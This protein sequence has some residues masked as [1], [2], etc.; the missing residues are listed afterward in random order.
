MLIRRKTFTIVLLIISLPVLAG[1][2]SGFVSELQA[3]LESPTPLPTATALPTSTLPA[4]APTE[5][6]IPTYAT[7]PTPTPGNIAIQNLSLPKPANTQ[8]PVIL[9]LTGFSENIN[10]LT[11]LE[12]ENI[13]K[14][15]RRPVLIKVSNYP[16]YGRPHAGLSFA[17][18][19]FE[20][21]IGEE[22]NRFLALYYS[23]DCEKVGPLR[24]GRLIDAQLVNMY[25][26]V[27]AYGNADPK[28][29][30]VL[31][32]ELD[33]RAI[34]FDDAAC[35]P[36]CGAETHSVAGVFVDTAALSD[37]SFGEGVDNT[38]KNLDGMLF[39]DD[40]PF[41][42][43]FAIQIGIEYSVRNRGE[44]H[45]DPDSGK[46]LRTIETN[47]NGTPE[48]RYPQIPL[49]DR[50]TNEQLAFSNVIIVFAEYVEFAPTLHQIL[51]WDVR[52]QQRAIF[53]RD[54]VMIDGYWRASDHYHP[55][56]FYNS[57][58]TPMALK[59]G[60]TWIV[61]VDP[62]SDFWQ[63]HDGRWELYF[64]LPHPTPTPEA[65]E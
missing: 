5:Q 26:G 40:V 2:Q 17:D 27:L 50:L 14:L 23:Q 18:I 54:G 42:N 10:P 28:V 33:Q 12:Q 56:H 30:K 16:R 49:V 46:Y 59:P 47:E 37:F 24:S 41:S 57:W 65:K 25:Q 43:Q 52:E 48:N 45:Y 8:V 55:M 63:A 64:D 38:R 61:I 21:Y 11:G 20:Y 62:L 29:D 19:V 39:D 1:C 44:W 53:F 13:E 7:H 15:E 34:S 3:I 4:S 6:V 31:V 60:N 32:D 58:G 51:V 35:P 22:A 9:G 36:I